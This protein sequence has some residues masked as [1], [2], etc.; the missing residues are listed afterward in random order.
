MLFHQPLV[1]NITPEP[2]KVAPPDDRLSALWRFT[3]NKEKFV[4]EVVQ[5][6]LPPKSTH[7]G[8]P[9]VDKI[10]GEL[11]NPMPAQLMLPMGVDAPVKQIQFDHA[12]SACL[13]VPGAAFIMAATITIFTI[14]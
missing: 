8:S 14:L 10:K 11:A 7:P 2:A 9:R 6:L 1:K 13:R 12:L 4:R 5:V 3:I